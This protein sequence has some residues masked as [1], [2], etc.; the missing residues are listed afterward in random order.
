MNKKNVLMTLGMLACCLIPL[1]GLAAIF[2]FNIP[3]NTVLLVGMVLFCPLSHLLMMKFMP[4]HNHEA[5]T[6]QPQQPQL[7][8]KQR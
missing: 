1:V 8:E 5:H 4:G 3:V 6:T 7:P 2:I